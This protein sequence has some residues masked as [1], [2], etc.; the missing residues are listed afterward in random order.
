VSLAVGD[1]PQTVEVLAPNDEEL[2][3]LE[4]ER[5]G[6]KPDVL[7]DVDERVVV[8]VCVGIP[9]D[10]PARADDIVELIRFIVSQY[11]WIA[12]TGGRSTGEQLQ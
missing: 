4:V 11:R 9:V 7:E 6:H 2:P 10:G 8:D 5:G 1:R 12:E 3:R